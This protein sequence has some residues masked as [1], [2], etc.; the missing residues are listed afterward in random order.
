MSAAAQVHGKHGL[1]EGISG[2]QH[3]ITVT[4][5]EIPGKSSE[6]SA[7]PLAL[8]ATCSRYKQAVQLRMPQQLPQHVAAA[9]GFLVHLS[10]QRLTTRLSWQNVRGHA[11]SDS[12]RAAVAPSR[13][14]TLLRLLQGALDAMVLIELRPTPR[15]RVAAAD[16]RCS[17]L[18]SSRSAPLHAS[19]PPATMLRRA[20]AWRFFVMA[21]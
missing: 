18:V 10:C 8:R 20:A 4:A 15:N 12:Y 16:G 11:I 13:V 21:G 9:G 6:P 14:G 5:S 2:P 3:V 19:A 7:R 17:M 1:Q